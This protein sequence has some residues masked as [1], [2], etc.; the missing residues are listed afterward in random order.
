MI[1]F[2]SLTSDFGDKWNTESGADPLLQPITLIYVNDLAKGSQRRATEIK[3]FA[4]KEEISQTLV[5]FSFLFILFCLRLRFVC[6]VVTVVIFQ[7]KIN[8]I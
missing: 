5:D 6:N 2:P 1:L 3:T 7:E 8:S 4:Q